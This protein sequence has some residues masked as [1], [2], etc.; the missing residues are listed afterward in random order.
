MAA[1]VGSRKILNDVIDGQSLVERHKAEGTVTYMK[2]GRLVKKGTTDYDVKIA[3]A[4]ANFPAIGWLGYEKANANF[5][6]ETIDTAYALADEVPVENGSGFR[7]RARLANGQN[8]VKGIRLKEAA[9]GE[10]TAA[11]LGTDHVIASMA[12]SVDASGAAA[13]AWVLS[14]I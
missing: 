10:V 9:N 13:D 3:D 12:E 2:P 6:P 5:K 4:S 11:T 8:L 1:Q 14:E 7:V